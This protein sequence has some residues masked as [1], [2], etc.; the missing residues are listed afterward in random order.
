MNKDS[1]III[2]IENELKEKFDEKCKSENTDMS[3]KLLM[4][5]KKYIG[6]NYGKPTIN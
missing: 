2:R 5:I 4:F 1:N 3:K 6:V